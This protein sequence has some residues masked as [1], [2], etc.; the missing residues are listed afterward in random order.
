VRHTNCVV[1]L[2]PAVA[3]DADA[4]TD[5]YLRSRSDAEPQMPPDIHTPDEVRRYVGAVLIA[6]RETWLAQVGG[7]PVGVL[8]LG[9]D[10]VDWLFVHPDAQ[11]RGVGSALLDHAKSRRP[12][13]LALWVF[14]SN[15]SAQRFYER[16]GFVAVRRTDGA[17]NEEHQPDVRYVWG[18]HPEHG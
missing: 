18:D 13:G 3:A 4:V 12:D 6:Q 8:V 5:I 11:G 15:T 1:R 16:H 14:E 9:A 17:D 2:R 10:D 7:T